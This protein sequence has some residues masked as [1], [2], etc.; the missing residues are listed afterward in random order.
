MLT[1]RI[2][3]IIIVILG[4]TLIGTSFYIKSQVSS[5]REQISE[6]EKKV[7]KGK[8]LFSTNPITKE[9]G[10]GI[11]DSAERKIKAGSAKADRYATLALWFQIGGGILIVVGGV[12]IFMKRKKN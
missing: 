4:I 2:S 6:A 3:G 8:E 1:K 7:Q 12:L 9:L 10:K 5:G 11:T